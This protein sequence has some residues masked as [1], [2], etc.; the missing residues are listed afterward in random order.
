ML[1]TFYTI[2]GSI[3]S[4]A[5][6]PVQN[7]N[8]SQVQ[9]FIKVSRKTRRVSKV[10]RGGQLQEFTNGQTWGMIGVTNMYQSFLH[11]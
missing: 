7:R 9:C 4:Q 5:I 2:F 8:S 3:L 1:E 11:N 10:N 6:I